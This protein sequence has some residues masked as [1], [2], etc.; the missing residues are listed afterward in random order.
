MGTGCGRGRHVPH[1]SAS[2]TTSASARCRASERCTCSRYGPKR[3]WSSHTPRAQ[4]R[5]DPR[6]AL[7]QNQQST[8]ALP[9]EAAGH[10]ATA[11]DIG[12][13][14]VTRCAALVAVTVRLTVEPAS[15]VSGTTAA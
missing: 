10:S 8:Q 3:A 7:A 13:L 2:S 12:L 1:W 11:T 14:S 15:A 4:N 9:H 5:H 6:A